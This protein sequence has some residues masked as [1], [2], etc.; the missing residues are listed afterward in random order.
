MEQK[1]RKEAEVN[2][3]AK[4]KKQNDNPK[5]KNSDNRPYRAKKAKKWREKFR[6]I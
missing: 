3:K 2:Q 1:W 4:C 6:L 5:S